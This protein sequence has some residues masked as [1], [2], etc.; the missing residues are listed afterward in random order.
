MKTLIWIIIVAALIFGAMK[1]YKEYKAESEAAQPTETTAT[2]KPES[3]T[4]STTESTSKSASEK[5]NSEKGI[6]NWRA[7]KKVRDLNEK[8]NKDL[9]KN[10]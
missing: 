3:K 6:Q 9:M 5:P 1:L 7:I 4:E 2:A 8:H 10:M